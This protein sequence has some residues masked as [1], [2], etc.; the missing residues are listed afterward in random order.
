[1]RT[2]EHWT[3]LIGWEPKV[4]ECQKMRLVGRD[5][6]AD[7]FFGPGRI[8]IDGGQGIK[9]MTYGNAADESAAFR[10][11]RAALDNPY[12]HLEQLRLF[13]T[14]YEGNEWA[15]GYTFIDPSSFDHKQGWLLS[16][17]LRGLSTRVSGPWVAENESIELLFDPSFD[18]P[19]AEWSATTTTLGGEEIGWSRQPYRQVIEVL[20]TKVIFEQDFA[21]RGLWLTA[22]TSEQLM[23]P[24]AE[25][26]LSQP[27]RILLGALIYPRLTA[28]NFGEGSAFVTLLPAPRKVRPSAFGLMQ[29]IGLDVGHDAEFWRLYANILVMIVAERMNGSPNMDDHEVTRLYV[30]LAQAQAGSRWVTVLTL[31]SMIEALAKSLMSDEDRRSEFSDKELAA[32]KEYLSDWGGHKM[33]SNRM[34]SSLANVSNRSPLSFLRGLAKNEK[35]ENAHVSTWQRLR[36]SVMHGELIE[37]WSTEEGDQ[38]LRELVALVHTLTKLRIAQ[39]NNF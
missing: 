2:L 6:E 13:A 29:P 31:A 35:I 1:M 36:N 16:G 22:Q 10:K 19:L 20:D 23:H 14:D 5:F 32:M 28:R 15:G 30:E 7:V 21:K 11:M 24:F 9:F 39:E 12:D 37:P 33:L 17:D 3:H 4:I 25:R 34:M 18:L 26:W 8:E 38:H 27:L